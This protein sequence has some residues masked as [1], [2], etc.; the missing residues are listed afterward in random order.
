MAVA[1]NLT[2]FEVL[3]EVGHASRRTMGGQEPLPPLVY[4]RTLKGLQTE[5]R[6]MKEAKKT[7]YTI[8]H[9]SVVE[10]GGCVAVGVVAPLRPNIFIHQID[11]DV[12]HLD[13]NL[14]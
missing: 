3:P 11:H 14:L 4:H 5:T 9:C 2:Q 7:D 12:D 6:P 13:P 1:D 10:G 8:G